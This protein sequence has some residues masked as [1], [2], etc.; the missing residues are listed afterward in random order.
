MIIYHAANLYKTNNE[1]DRDRLVRAQKTWSWLY[2]VN[3][4]RIKP[5]YSTLF[6]RSS[7]DLGDQRSIPFV[8]DVIAAA[9]AKCSEHDAVMLTN[10]DSSLCQETADYVFQGLFKNQCCYSSR[11]DMDKA[12][13][14]WLKQSE[15][16]SRGQTFIGIDLVAFTRKWWEEHSTEYPDMLLGFS[17]WDF[18]FKFL[19][20][21]DKEIETVVYHE[22]HGIPEWH[23]TFYTSAGQN[24]NRRLAIEWVKKRPDFER[25]KK[26]WPSIVNYERPPIQSAGL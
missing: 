2:S 18:I 23:R 20:G 26:R 10:A 15:I 6:N 11:M 14:V 12:Y 4:D 21:E 8:K 1:R 16:K 17:G 3:H 13:R 9:I 5:A 25:I 7:S 19:M 24:Y 22:M